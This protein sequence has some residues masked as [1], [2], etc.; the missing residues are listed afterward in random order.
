MSLASLRSKE[1]RDKIRRLHEDLNVESLV[2][3]S[4]N[5]VPQDLLEKST[6]TQLFP[7]DMLIVFW[8]PYR[9][10]LSNLEYIMHTSQCN[11]MYSGSKIKAISFFSDVETVKQTM[12]IDLNIYICT[13]LPTD[14][15]Q[16]LLQ[17][18][19][20]KA[21]CMMVDQYTDST[22]IIFSL[23]PPTVSDPD[24][25]KAWMADQFSVSD[26]SDGMCTQLIAVDYDKDK[27]KIH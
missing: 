1:T 19:I 18:L 7:D 24:T 2:S 8:E 5:H 10:L 27:L 16:K 4:N 12:R 26:R 13:D 14:E 17:M 9:P 11:I 22:N 23:Y 3:V 6:Q 15:Q 25:I 21:I 20:I